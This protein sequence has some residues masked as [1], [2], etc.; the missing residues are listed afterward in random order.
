M[1]H[2]RDGEDCSDKED[3][4]WPEGVPHPDD[5]PAYFGR[6]GMM[7]SRC[8]DTP[9]PDTPLWEDPTYGG[10]QC[11]LVCIDCWKRLHIEQLSTTDRIEDSGWKSYIDPDSGMLWWHHAATD[12][13][14]WEAPE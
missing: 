1:T 2:F 3:V 9:N 12:K 11:V 7:C 4:L 10:E 6:E 8:R 5:Y 14:Q 13:S